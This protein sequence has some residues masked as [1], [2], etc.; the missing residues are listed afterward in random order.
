MPD[1]L[2]N[3]ISIFIANFS[4][5]LLSSETPKLSVG[6]VIFDLDGTLIDSAPIY[7][8]IIDVIFERLNIPPVP[9]RTLLEAMKDGEFEWDLVLPNEMKIRKEDLIG[10]ARGIVDEIAPVM[11][12]E[13]VK[14]LPGA[15][16]MLN[17]IAA[18]GMRLAMVT[19]TLRDYMAVKLSPLAVEGVDELF[20]V[21][22][23]ADDVR[24]KKPHAE[25]LTMCCDRLGLDP[26]HCV[27]VGDTRVDIKA[28]NA[29]GMQTLGVLTGFDDYD[30]LQAE[31]PNAIIESVADLNSVLLM[32]L[33][34]GYGHCPD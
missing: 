13:Q 7:Y 26:G 10:E 3:F 27:Y 2:I 31:A 32:T 5:D 23:T 4:E 33:M 18:E 6:A 29:A 16:D 8:S 30:A 17:A 1:G 28:G 14:L 34:P 25:P 20:E 11:F 22:I 9:R 21:I 19:S 15:A 24:N 12:Q